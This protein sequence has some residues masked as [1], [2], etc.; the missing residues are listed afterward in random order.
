MKAPVLESLFNK[1]AGLKETTPQ[2]FSCEYHKIFK[3]SFLY[4][5]SWVAASENGRRISKKF[6]FNFRWIC[7][8]EFIRFF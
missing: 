6:K 7:A 1:I 2:L 8:E 5:T 3:N 4:G